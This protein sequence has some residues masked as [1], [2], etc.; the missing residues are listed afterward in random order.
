MSGDVKV[1]TSESDFK[2]K[3]NPLGGILNFILVFAAFKIF[4]LLPALAGLL[5]FWGLKAKIGTVWAFLLSLI[6]MILAGAAALYYAY[7]S[8]I[9]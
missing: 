6:V 2:K 1:S 8:G 4:G 3:S 5:V 9:L 7:T